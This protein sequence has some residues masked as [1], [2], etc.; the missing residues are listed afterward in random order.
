[1]PH[2]FPF[3]WIFYYFSAAHCGVVAYETCALTSQPASHGRADVVYLSADEM[4]KIFWVGGWAGA[5]K[6]PDNKKKKA[7]S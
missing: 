2:S 1:M 7:R 3:N 5:T 4:V 6:K